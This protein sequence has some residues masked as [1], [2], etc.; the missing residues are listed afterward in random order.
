MNGL[1]K[2]YMFRI[3]FQTPE[4]ERIT[5]PGN[6]EIKAK[7]LDKLEITLKDV[8]V[9]NPKNNIYIMKGGPFFLK[10]DAEEIALKVR[11][12]ILLYFAEIRKGV[13]FGS[14]SSYLFIT[15]A[16]EE[17]FKKLSGASKIYPDNF[18]LTIYENKEGV[19]FLSSN[20]SIIVGTS[21]N[22]L[23]MA[24][25]NEFKFPK[26]L[27]ERELLTLEIFTSSYFEKTNTS[28]FLKLMI[29]VESL[30][31]F[32]EKDT[33]TKNMIDYCIEYINKSNMESSKKNLLSSSIGKLKKESITEAGIRVSNEYLSGKQYHSMSPGEFFKS[34]YSLRSDL[35]H[36]GNISPEVDNIQGDFVNFVGDMIKAKILTRSTL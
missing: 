6:N 35:L 17:Y 14:F 26:T 4:N 12:S 29:C 1:E 33:E 25:E 11:N 34:C 18:G 22:N 21:G 16:G 13:Y 27:N 15:E 23:M 7:L 2:S 28:R 32:V 8:S 31:D 30:L 20:P 24:I 9:E 10:E 19:K 5:M 36:N 3:K